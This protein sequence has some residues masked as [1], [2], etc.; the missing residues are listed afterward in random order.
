MSR[1]GA[2]VALPTFWHNR[3]EAAAE[4]L[5]LRAENYLLETISANTPEGTVA[6]TVAGGTVAKFRRR[7]EPRYRINGNDRLGWWLVRAEPGSDEFVTAPGAQVFADVEEA[8]QTAWASGIVLDGDPEII[9]VTVEDEAT[10]D[11]AAGQPDDDESDQSGGGD[12]Q[13]DSANEWSVGE[14]RRPREPPRSS[15]SWDDARKTYHIFAR[16]ASSQD[17][18]ECVPP[19]VDRWLS[20]EEPDP[21]Y[22]READI[23]AALDAVGPDVAGGLRQLCDFIVKY[24]EHD[25]AKALDAVANDGDNHHLEYDTHREVHRVLRFLTKWFDDNF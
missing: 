18:T 2:W 8:T 24:D 9:E 25:L 3:E 5:R 19:V 17:S 13:D 23:F 7:G 16:S 21:K 6:T 11:K 10:A 20:G 4:A 15:D 14:L 12:D 22:P 1:N